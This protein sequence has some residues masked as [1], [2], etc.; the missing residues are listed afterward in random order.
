M[1]TML[2]RFESELLRTSYTLSSRTEHEFKYNVKTG[3]YIYRE[4]DVLVEKDN[5]S[6]IDFQKKF[7]NIYKSQTTFGYDGSE[8]KCLPPNISVISGCYGDKQ[9]N[10]IIIRIFTNKYVLKKCWEGFSLFNEYRDFTGSYGLSIL[11]N[12]FNDMAPRFNLSR[13]KMERGCKL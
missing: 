12:F 8:S 3:L 5:I 10:W 11:G 9:D 6:Y 13:E 2:T 1:G 4:N 7:Y